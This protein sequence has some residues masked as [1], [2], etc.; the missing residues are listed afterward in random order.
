M[1]QAIPAKPTAE[2]ETLLQRHQGLPEG[3]RQAR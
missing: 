2:F 3:G 1:Y